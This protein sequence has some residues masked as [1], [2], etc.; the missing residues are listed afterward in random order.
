MFSF[1]HIFNISVE[2]LFVLIRPNIFTTQKVN[3]KTVQTMSSSSQNIFSG[4]YLWL[5]LLQWKAV[6]V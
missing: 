5:V 6:Y 2:K 4:P 1:N 3:T